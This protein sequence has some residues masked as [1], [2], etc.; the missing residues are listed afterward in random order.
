MRSAL[1]R[2]AAASALAA[3]ALSAASTAGASELLNNGGFENLGS[4]VPEGW[5]GY[6][7]YAGAQVGLPGWTID[8]GSVDVTT[9]ASA[10]SPA[11]E[12]QNGLDI[13]GWD[14]GTIS[15]SFGTILG[16]LYTVSFAYS[17]NAASAPN[18]ATATVS[19][20]GSFLDVTAAND[21]SFGSANN[22]LWKTGSFTF[23]GTGNNETITLA[24]T[25]PGNGGVFFDN[26]S[27]SGAAVPEPA[28]WALMIGG[29][30]MAGATL[31]RR[32]AIGAA[33]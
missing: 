3:L 28:T 4:A 33:A 21:G 7:Y 30:G 10:W 15:Q 27:V 17:R 2:T 9:N 25:V 26:V 19:A 5:G 1:L 11:Y 16:E 18:P 23:V 20:G 12:G 24:A 31:R 32:R 6:T 29:F 13:N 14:A 22:F 8:A